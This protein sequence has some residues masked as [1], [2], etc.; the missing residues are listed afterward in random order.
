[1]ATTTGDAKPRDMNPLWRRPFLCV[2]I[3][4]TMAGL[5]WAA[6]APLPGVANDGGAGDSQSRNNE[7]RETVFEIP[8]GTWAHRMA[9][10]KVE[11][12]PDRIY[13]TL[14]IKDILVLKNLDDVPQ[15]FGPT[16]IMPQ[17]SFKLPFDLAADYQFACTAH[18]SGQM[19]I[20]VEPLPTLGWPRLRWRMKTVMRSWPGWLG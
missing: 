6:L 16:L 10:D 17:Q 4:L 5:S 1:M 15:I 9:G 13:L 14:G 3:G 20:V 11:I 12:L 19:T 8:K 2:L 18:A 7:S